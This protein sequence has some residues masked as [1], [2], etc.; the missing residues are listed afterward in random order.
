MAH[1]A[2]LNQENVVLQVIVV[3]N[4]VLIDELGNESEQKGIDF[5]NEWWYVRIRQQSKRII[6]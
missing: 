6:Y 4:D 3:N 1:F 5:C 2:E